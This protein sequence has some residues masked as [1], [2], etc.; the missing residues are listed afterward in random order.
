MKDKPFDVWAEVLRTTFN[1]DSVLRIRAEK[2]IFKEGMN[3]LVDSLV[4]G[5]DTTAAPVKDF[6]YTDV[7]GKKLTAPEDVDDVR[8]QVISDYQDSLEKQWV[9]GLRKRY[10]VVVDEKVLATVNKH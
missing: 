5:K 3:A 7:Y 2:G 4:F 9:E 10:K 6:P 8:Q 1:N